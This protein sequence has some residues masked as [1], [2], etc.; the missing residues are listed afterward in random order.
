MQETEQFTETQQEEVLT[1][2]VQTRLLLSSNF[3]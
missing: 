1:L 2:Q 3:I